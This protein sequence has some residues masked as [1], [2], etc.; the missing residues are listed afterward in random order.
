MSCRILISLAA[1]IG[2]STVAGVFWAKGSRDVL[3][4]GPF[5]GAL[6]NTRVFLTATARKPFWWQWPNPLDN[7]LDARWKALGKARALRVKV[8]QRSACMGILEH[9]AGRSSRKKGK[10][11]SLPLRHSLCYVAT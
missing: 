8:R 5:N 4:D 9:I 2:V 11:E 1:G 7:D 6:K 3:L 10:N